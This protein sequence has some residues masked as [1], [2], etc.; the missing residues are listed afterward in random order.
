MSHLSSNSANGYCQIWTKMLSSKKSRNCCLACWPQSSPRPST[1]D[2]NPHTPTHQTQ[3]AKPRVRFNDR[4]RKIRQ[5]KERHDEGKKNSAKPEF[6]SHL[7]WHRSSNFWP[8]R[9]QQNSARS[10]FGAV[11]V[12]LWWLLI[13]G[14]VEILVIVHR[15]MTKIFLQKEIESGDVVVC[16]AEARVRQ[17]LERIEMSRGLG[18]FMFIVF[19]VVIFGFL[20]VVNL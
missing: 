3:P 13:S 2:G 6:W 14:S 10:G 5:G 9:C 1:I 17:I 8:N 16:L 7:N 18:F 19:F 12:V 11:G 15:K 4:E 20:K